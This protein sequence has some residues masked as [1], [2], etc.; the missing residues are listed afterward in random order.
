MLDERHL[1]LGR[2]SLEIR[3]G[4]MTI[5]TL[6]MGNGIDW[7]NVRRDSHVSQK[8]KLIRIDE[9]RP[10]KEFHRYPKIG[11]FFSRLLYALD[12]PFGL[13]FVGNEGI[14]MVRLEFENEVCNIV[15]LQYRCGLGHKIQA[16]YADVFH[17]GPV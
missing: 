16:A 5:I 3:V 13:D 17:N 14:R 11:G 6:F 1:D 8:G 9:N 4:D 7:I 2:P 10:R 15:R 12:F